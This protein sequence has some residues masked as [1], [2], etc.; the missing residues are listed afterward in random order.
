MSLLAPVIPLLASTDQPDLTTMRL[1]LNLVC[2][3]SKPNMHAVQ[4]G[5][6][7]TTPR[8]SCFFIVKCTC[9]EALFYRCNK[10]RMHYASQHLRN[11]VQTLHHTNLTHTIIQLR[12]MT[13]TRVCAPAC[14]LCP[15]MILVV[16]CDSFSEAAS[17][18]LFFTSGSLICFWY[19]SFNHTNLLL[20]LYPVP[21]LFA[22]AGSPE[23]TCGELICSD[24]FHDLVSPQTS[25]S[26]LFSGHV[27]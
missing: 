21:F 18:Y 3:V 6:T 19:F 25:P 14:S 17:L 23:V 1:Q 4:L 12:N 13:L 16:R 2:L 27:L 20:A 24:S 7:L 26:L 10:C 15:C 11:Y 8:Q 22:V 9:L 5:R